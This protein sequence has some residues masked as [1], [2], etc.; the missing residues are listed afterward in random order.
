MIKIKL[1]EE[2]NILL[3][4]ENL[5]LKKQVE[6]NKLIIIGLLKDKQNKRKSK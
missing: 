1:L 2:E 5:L 4:Q 3:K 6:K